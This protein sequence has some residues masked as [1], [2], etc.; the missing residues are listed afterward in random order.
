MIAR[1]AETV[2]LAPGVRHFV[3]EAEVDGPFEFEPGQ[4]VSLSAMIEDRE[5]TRAYSLAGVPDGRRFELCLN[6]V[7]DGLFS[8]YL[9]SMK[10]GDSVNVAGPLG[11]FVWKK[12]VGRSVLVAT[13]T[14]IA[15]FRGMLKKLWRASSEAPVTLVFGVRYEENLLYRREFEEMAGHWPQF[16]FWPTLSR[17]GESWRGRR[18]HVQAHAMEA[19]RAGIG[20][21]TVYICGL[22]AMVDDLRSQLKSAGLDR[23]RIVYEK[24]D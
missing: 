1:L 14:G 18:G 17:G 7:D 5:I 23:K 9:F 6:C 22:K 21:V 10:M 15:P 11:Y 24:F 4:F 12:P 2:E 16:Q 19:V 20:D 3:F 13:G 8:P